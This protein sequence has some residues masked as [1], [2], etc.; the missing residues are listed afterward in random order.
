MTTLTVRLEDSGQSQTELL[1]RLSS[2]VSRFEKM[3]VASHARVEPVYPD[4][5]IS[6]RKT[7]FLVT[8]DGQGGSRLVEALVESPGVIHA[9]IAPDRGVR[10]G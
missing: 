7:T 4:Q 5:T 10:S 8:L 9:F 1:E 2:L 6:R 3:G